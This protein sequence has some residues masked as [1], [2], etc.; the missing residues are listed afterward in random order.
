MDATIEAVLVAL[1]APFVLWALW[2]AYRAR[3]WRWVFTVVLLM[4]IGAL[5]WFIAGRRSYGYGQGTTCEG[6]D[7][8]VRDTAHRPNS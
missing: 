7:G 5:A 4:P 8:R 3:S 1:T 6:S 2:E